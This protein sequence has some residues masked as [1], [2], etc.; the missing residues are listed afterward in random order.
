DLR[1][2][3]VHAVFSLPQTVVKRYFNPQNP[4]PQH[5]AYV[6]WF[7]AFSP[8]P[9]THSGLYKVRRLVRDTERQVSIVPVS[10]ICRSA[11]LLPKWGGAVPA[12]W[13]SLDVLDTSPLFF[14]NVFKDTYTYFNVG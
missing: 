9:D 3:Q 11:H 7:S 12:E 5:F 2:V 8:L 1:V 14:L 6:E 10:L 13:M 4:P